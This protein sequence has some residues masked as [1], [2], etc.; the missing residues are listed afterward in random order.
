MG[1]N[2]DD[3]VLVHHDAA[4]IKALFSHGIRRFASGSVNRVARKHKLG[5]QEIRFH[6]VHLGFV[7]FASEGSVPRRLLQDLGV[8]LVHSG[9]RA[10]SYG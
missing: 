7:E 8:E 1:L 10:Y 6:F 9:H 2:G 5:L 3:K 4:G